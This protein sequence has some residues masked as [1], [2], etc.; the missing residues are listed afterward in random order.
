M[1]IENR[2]SLLPDCL[3]VEILSR[4]DDTKYA[5]R[6]G[7]L[8]KRWQHLWPQLSNLFFTHET[9]RNIPQFYSSL[10][11][12]LTS[13]THQV[14]KLKLHAYY[15]DRTEV[16]NCIF[17]AISRNVQEVDFRMTRHWYESLHS[18]VTELGYVLPAFFFTCSSF[19]HV[20]LCGG[21]FQQAGVISWENLKTLHI[22][23]TEIDQNMF[24]NIL[25]GSP[26]LETLELFRCRGI[27]WIDITTNKSVKNLRLKNCGIIHIN[28]PYILSLAIKG[29]V[30]FKHLMLLNVSSLIK[31]ELNYSMV[32][33]QIHEE[34]E[35]ILKG[36]LLSLAH[37]KEVII[38]GSSLEV[39]S[40]F[41]LYLANFCACFDM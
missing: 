17:S 28:A 3:L 14:N 41:F 40:T 22:R 16:S 39:H 33:Q 34:E 12:I 7:T 35:E 9:G 11:R 30:W 8:S 37:A 24:E 4:L 2:I 15:N 38:G 19:I 13:Q 23:A 21:L 6:T 18:Y 27:Q 26:L 31:V 25:S 29:H 32:M 36:H 10:K 1:A 5:I 20:R